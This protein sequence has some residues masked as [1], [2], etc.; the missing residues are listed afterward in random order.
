MSSAANGAQR[1]PRPESFC[2]AK[3][4]VV[5]PIT[6]IPKYYFSERFFSKVIL[7]QA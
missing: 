5:V 4:L 2:A 3:I 7:L 1:K 6:T